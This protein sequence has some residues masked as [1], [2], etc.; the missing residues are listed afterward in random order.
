MYKT[1]TVSVTHYNNR[2]CRLNENGCF[3]YFI[4]YTYNVYNFRMR[5]SDVLVI[6][7]N[8]LTGEVMKNIVLAGI[9]SLTILD[10]AEV[11]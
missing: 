2:M 8:G 9:N 4:A 10:N 1:Y 3:R 11:S 5:A 7:A 6:G